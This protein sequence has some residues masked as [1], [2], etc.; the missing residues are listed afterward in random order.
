MNIIGLSVRLPTSIKS[1][2]FPLKQAFSTSFDDRRPPNNSDQRSQNNN[3]RRPL[4]NNDRRPQNNND[5]RG[6]PND[7]DNRLSN[8]NNHRSPN[9]K[10]HYFKNRPA[11]NERQAPLNS[12]KKDDN[13]HWNNMESRQKQLKVI[14]SGFSRFA[15]RQDLLNVLGPIKPISIDPML[16]KSHYFVG[17][18]HLTLPMSQNLEVL[19]KHLDDNWKQTG[20]GLAITKYSAT[21]YMFDPMQSV[22]SSALHITQNTIKVKMMRKGITIDELYL[23]FENYDLRIPRGKAIEWIPQSDANYLVH[24]ATPE[25]AERAIVEQSKASACDEIIQLCHYSC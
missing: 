20:D 7:F 3:D 13:P 1:F 12:N 19:R 8:N 21:M 10:K 25:E 23:I 15:C 18:Y 11:N 9:P 2:C 5:N 4:N 24:F 16:D 6:P 17:K 22:L 14:V